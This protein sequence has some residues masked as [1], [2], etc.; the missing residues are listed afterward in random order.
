MPENLV[1]WEASKL[2]IFH[3]PQFNIT[4]GV[5][6]RLTSCICFYQQCILQLKCYFANG[7]R[8]NKSQGQGYNVEEQG[9]VSSPVLQQQVKHFKLALPWLVNKTLKLHFMPLHGVMH[10]VKL[11]GTSVVLSTPQF[12]SQSWRGCLG[13][14]R[15]HFSERSALIRV[16]LKQL[17]S[18]MS[19]ARCPS[20]LPVYFSFKWQKR[21]KY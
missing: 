8:K 1:L 15:P 12:H 7:K 14:S 11:P 21:C 2:P 16:F 3:S 4:A 18:Y 9:F 19:Q 5:M 20:H 10:L 13:A 6:L 17:C